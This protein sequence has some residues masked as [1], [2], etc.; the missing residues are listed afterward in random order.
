MGETGISRKRIIANEE[1][2]STNF[3]PIVRFVTPPRNWIR[4]G[5]PLPRRSN[6]LIFSEGIC[7]NDCVRKLCGKNGVLC[8]VKVGV[9]C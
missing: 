8:I 4:Q 2:L 5:S 3:K 9:F 7:I 6:S 1:I